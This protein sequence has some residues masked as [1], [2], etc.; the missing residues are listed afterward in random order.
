MWPKVN[1]KVISFIKVRL[2][3]FQRVVR[4]RVDYDRLSIRLGKLAFT[5]GT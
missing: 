2:L 4:M 1:D 5:L 3:R